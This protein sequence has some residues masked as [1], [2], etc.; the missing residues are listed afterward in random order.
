MF[1]KFYTISIKNHQSAQILTRNKTFHFERRKKNENLDLKKITETPIYSN[2]I[3]FR[4][5]KSSF[6]SDHSFS[7]YKQFV[8][9]KRIFRTSSN[10]LAIKFPK[11][12]I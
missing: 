12:I 4:L 10:F 1:S 3:I 6:Q 9:P 8:G 11:K 2:L 7:C 5:V